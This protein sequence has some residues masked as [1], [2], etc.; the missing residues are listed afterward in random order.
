MAENGRPKR[1][2]ALVL[3]LAAGR[4]VR[5]ACCKAGISE[6]TAFRRLEDSAFRRRVTEVRADMVQRALGKLA[7]NAAAAAD[8]LRKLL[9]ADGE[10]VKLGAARSILELGNRLRESVELEQRLAALEQ[11]LAG[12]DKQ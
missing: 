11:R 1:D 4:T 3:A 6:R 7:D 2:E 8:T 10:N 5:E 9:K 12:K